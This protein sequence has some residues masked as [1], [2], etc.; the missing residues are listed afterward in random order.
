MKR[1]F[2][3]PALVFPLV[4]LAQETADKTDKG[5]MYGLAYGLVIFL[6][7]I[8]A[9]SIYERVRDWMEDKEKRAEEEAK[10]K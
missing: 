5:T 1:I 3:F 8:G 10:K 7:L 6:A 9:Y 4:A 2:S